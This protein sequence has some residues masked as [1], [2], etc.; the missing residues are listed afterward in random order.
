MYIENIES[1][2][3]SGCT[4]KHLSFWVYIENTYRSGCTQKHLSFWVYIENINHSGCTQKVPIVL[5]VH[6]KYQSFWVYIENINHSGCTQKISIILGVHR[7]TYHSG[8]T[9][10]YLSFGYGRFGNVVLFCLLCFQ[11]Y[12][13]SPYPPNVNAPYPAQAG[14]YIV[15]I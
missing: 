9:Q 6:R 5:G 7:N 8:C 4:Q 11:G 2:Y 1:T 15:L 13:A 3:R 10:K 14:M 12:A